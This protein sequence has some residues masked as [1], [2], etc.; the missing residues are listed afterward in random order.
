MKYPSGIGAVAIFS[1]AAA[2]SHLRNSYLR[3]HV[4]QAPRSTSPAS[5]SPIPI[6]IRCRPPRLV[7]GHDAAAPTGHHA[8]RP[9]PLPVSA[10]RP[11]LRVAAPPGNRPRLP[12][13]PVCG[14]RRAG[15]R[16]RRG[17]HRPDPA[18]ELWSS[19]GQA[20][21]GEASPRCKPQ[22]AA[23]SWQP[24]PA[25]GTKQRASRSWGCPFVPL[26]L[27]ESCTRGR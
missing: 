20:G 9:P 24:S 11:L 10:E 19:G 13:F 15:Q 23:G 21:T 12:L 1:E 14:G 4:G 17:A 3:R 2:P 5:P 22:R 18:S 8:A 7:L 26:C 25:A 6:R 16:R 27:V